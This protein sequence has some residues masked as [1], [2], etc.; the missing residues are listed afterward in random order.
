MRNMAA[1]EKVDMDKASKH[2]ERKLLK[3]IFHAWQFSNVSNK[4]C[5]T[6][7]FKLSNP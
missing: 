6:G 2:H 5:K 7:L 3:K 1:A 4:Y